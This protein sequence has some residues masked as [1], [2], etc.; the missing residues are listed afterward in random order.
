M[1]DVLKSNMRLFDKAFCPSAILGWIQK[2]FVECLVRE[3][4]ENESNKKRTEV[5]I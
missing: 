4:S 5:N 3:F 1:L 2:E